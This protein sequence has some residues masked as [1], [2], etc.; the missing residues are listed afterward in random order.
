M[1]NM[2]LTSYIRLFVSVVIYAIF[3]LLFNAVAVCNAFLKQ[4]VLKVHQ[5]TEAG[6][7]GG[8]LWKRKFHEFAIHSVRN[9]ICIYSSSVSPEYIFKP[10]VTLYSLTKHEAVFVETEEDIDINSSD[11]SPFFTFA[12]FSR[13]K[14]VIKIPIHC[15][16]A[17]ADKV[18]G[19]SLPVI[20]V[21]QSGRCGSTILCQ[22]LENIPGT[23][24]IA[25]PDPPAI[26]DSMY[27][28]Q[29]I[30]EEERDRLLISTIKLLCKPHAGTKRICIKTTGYCVSLV[31]PISK[32][33]PDFNQILM[34]RNCE[35]TV[36]SY[37][38]FLNYNPLIKVLH[39]LMDSDWLKF[40]KRF[41]KKSTEIDF[42]RKTKESE[43]IA[44]DTKVTCTVGVFTY[45]WANYIFVLRD[46]MRHDKSIFAVKY[47]DILADKVETF[48][49]V[50]EKLGLDLSNLETA[51]TAFDKDSQ[52]G[53]VV[54]RSRV[55]LSSTNVI[56][57]KE[58]IEADVILSC[59]TLPRMGDDFRI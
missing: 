30:S 41:V 49:D 44:A 33:F 20:W 31:K 58:R 55:G 6:L 2:Q 19:P 16:H 39:I 52:R 10:N 3:R 13:C 46:A 17:L 56:S 57:D 25:E 9:F 54:S 34:Y 18:G 7:F 40:A 5:E 53:T 51:L 23:L 28:T 47:E 32:L 12:Q 29:G 45:M 15:F 24:V 59:Y 22:V 21:S 4:T 14:N 26:I 50:F 37:V 35:E 27:R 42:I 11:E 8:I 36:T 48:R 38:A 43:A 1:A